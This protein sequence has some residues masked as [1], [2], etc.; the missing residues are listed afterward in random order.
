MSSFKYV[1]A[2]TAGAAIGS[3]VTWK[4]LK[5]KYEQI[6]QE[7]IDSVKEV[8]ARHRKPAVEDSEDDEEP[9]E[10][11]ENR[12]SE[13]GYTNV[14]SKETDKPSKSDRPY[15]ISPEEFGSNEDYECISLTYYADGV[16]TEYGSEEP[17]DDVDDMVGL[18]SLNEFGEFEDDCVRVRNDAKKHDYEI[19]LDEKKYSDVFGRKPRQVED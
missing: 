6:A 5:T 19:L 3:V 13:Y 11:Y 17:I 16:L 7:E 18:D 4:L 14:P 15:V 9:K 8:F 10:E 12:V 1:V 2:F